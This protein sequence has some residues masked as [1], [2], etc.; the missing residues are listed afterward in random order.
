MRG[1]LGF[2]HEGYSPHQDAD[3]LKPRVPAII[4]HFTAYKNQDHGAWLR[5]GD[6]WLDSCR[7]ADNG[8]GLTLASGGTFPYDDGSKQEIKNSLFVGESGNV[9]TKMRTAGSGAPAAWTRAGG[10]CP[11]ASRFAR[12]AAASLRVADPE[13][14]EGGADGF[15]EVGPTRDD[16]LRAARLHARDPPSW[17]LRNVRAACR[18]PGPAC[19]AQV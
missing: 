1:E 12:T 6:V 13:R 7:F 9:G 14:R 16:V 5:G 8:I 10:P 18:V 4:K 15:P 2:Q 19:K 3:P 11:S 17:A